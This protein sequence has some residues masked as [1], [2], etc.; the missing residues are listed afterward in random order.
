MQSV[1]KDSLET[2]YQQLIND[3]YDPQTL[4]AKKEEMVSAAKRE[5]VGVRDQEKNEQLLSGLT[6]AT[7][8]KLW[9]T[10]A[11]GTMLDLINFCKGV[12]ECNKILKRL[13]PEQ[14]QTIVIVKLR[15]ATKINECGEARLEPT[16][17]EECKIIILWK[18]LI[19]LYKALKKI[20]TAYVAFADNYVY[21]PTYVQ[22]T[23]IE[24]QKFPNPPW[25]ISIY[26]QDNKPHCGVHTY[27]SLNDPFLFVYPPRF[28]LHEFNGK[29]FNVDDLF[30]T[31][32]LST[33]GFAPF[34]EIC[35]NIVCVYPMSPNFLQITKIGQDKI[36]DQETHYERNPNV[37]ARTHITGFTFLHEWKWSL[38]DQPDLDVADKIYVAKQISSRNYG[39]KN[40]KT[41]TAIKTVASKKKK[42]PTTPTPIKKRTTSRRRT[43][44]TPKPTPK[45][46]SNKRTLS[47]GK[48]RRTSPIFF[49]TLAPSTT[50]GG[51]AKK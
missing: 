23:Q 47:R 39:N 11:T 10:M 17:D 24:M 16:R 36:L 27:V 15:Q 1:E 8:T 5:L 40:D 46:T 41:K 44:P 33:H 51:L 21:K 31:F 22:A 3:S 14:K 20:H 43:K 12:G 49:E 7:Q 34:A 25:P 45:R 2:M 30:K 28:N 50:V 18:D 42:M 29:A 26:Q 32:N 19:N 35:I 48:S 6:E 37:P 13:S 9:H 4:L 38:A